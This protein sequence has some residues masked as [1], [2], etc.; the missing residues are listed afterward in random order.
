MVAQFQGMRLQMANL[1]KMMRGDSPMETAP[2]I[3]E[4]HARRRRPK[5][6]APK[7]LAMPAAAP[8]EAEPLAVE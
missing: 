2:P 4:G 6:A 3:P 5:G 7:P 1:G 8:E